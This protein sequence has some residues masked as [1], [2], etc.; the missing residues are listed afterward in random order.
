MSQP[1][2]AAEGNDKATI[3]GHDWGG[4]VA[5]QVAFAMPEMVENLVIMNLPH[6]NGLARELANNAE[7]QRNSEYAQRFIAGSADDPT[8]IGG[9]PMTAQSLSGW[10]RE[11]RRAR[12]ILA[13]VRAQRL[14]RH[15]EFL[16]SQLSKTRLKLCGST[17]HTTP[18][19]GHA[20]P[21]FPWIGR[22]GAAFRRP[23]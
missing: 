6:P 3:V 1:V 22:Y 2:V 7:Q 23:Q 12:A 18:A 5:W 8:I 17:Q 4:A 14:R 21:D 20:T 10:V 15:A 19:F 16:Q 13:G 9:N 11:A